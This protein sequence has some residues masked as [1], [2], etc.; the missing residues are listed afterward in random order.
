MFSKI[1]FQKLNK[2]FASLKGKLQKLRK[3]LIYMNDYIEDTENI[4]NI[5]VEL[6]DYSR[7]NNIRIDG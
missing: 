7:R 5:L 2:T 3:N 1:K 4:D 6:E